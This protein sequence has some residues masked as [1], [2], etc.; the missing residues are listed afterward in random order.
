VRDRQDRLAEIE[1]V[2]PVRLEGEEDG[3]V[4]AGHQVI[5]A[6]RLPGTQERGL[7]AV[8]DDVVVEAPRGHARTLRQIRVLLRRLI[9]EALEEYRDD[10]AQVRDHV[11]DARE[12]LG[13][14]LGD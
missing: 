3:V 10:A 4:A 9:V 2:L 13:Y 11:L 12:A 14:A 5:G 6:E 7:R 1:E 8:T